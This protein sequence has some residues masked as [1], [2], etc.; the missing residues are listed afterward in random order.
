MKPRVALLLGDPA[1]IGPELIARLIASKDLSRSAH[2]AVV[3]DQSV[4]AEGQRVAGTAVTLNSIDGI[5]ALPDVSGLAFLH[6]KESE[7]G[8]V[9]PG[10]V[11][12]AGGTSVL[13]TVQ[14][15]LKQAREGKLDGIMFAPFNKEALRLAGS[16]YPSELALF[17]HELGVTAT[18]G[19]HNVLGNLWTSRVSSHV[20]LAEV[21]ALITRERV[22]QTIQL[23]NGSLRN[24]GIRTPRIAVSALNP[25]G[26]DGG[27]FGSEEKTQIAPAIQ[28]AVAG[29]IAA[30]GPFP[31][32]TI[33]LRVKAE[34]YDGV[35]SMY[36]DQ[37]QIATK[38]LGFNRGV[39]VC[40]G[41]PIP[42]TTPA[43]GTAFDIAGK[44]V[45]NPGATKEAFRLLTRLAA[46]NLKASSK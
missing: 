2:V 39:T 10:R 38:L 18:Y 17:A 23:L 37:G 9:S 12:V 43:H 13:I 8:P 3:G 4:L 20:S 32:D 27:L 16:P 29:G 25:H 46:G 11:S 40:G 15:A 31:A 21:P 24:Y 33:F 45:A 28:D 19:E 34:R 44:G 7:V 41:L 14:F 35:V 42:I 36:H 6:L 5:D 26:S 1:G 30:F 22:L